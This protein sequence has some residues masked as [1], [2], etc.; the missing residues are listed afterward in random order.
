[1]SETDSFIQEVT[2]EVRQ[3][4]MLAY[5][6]KWGPFILGGVVLVV[7]AAAAWS[8]W[9]SQKQAQ[10]NKYQSPDIQEIHKIQQCG[11]IGYPVEKT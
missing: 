4:R 11:C 10:A 9:Q 8:W 2:E 5:W 6:K 7:G 3:D 1:M